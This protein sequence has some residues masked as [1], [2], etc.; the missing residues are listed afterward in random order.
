ACRPD[1]EEDRAGAAERRDVQPPAPELAYMPGHR[2]GLYSRRAG[3]A[4]V[5]YRVPDGPPSGRE[6][7]L[8]RAVCARPAD[9]EAPRSGRR[10][11]GR[12]R[13]PRAAREGSELDRAAL[14]RASPAHR[15]A[16]PPR[17]PG[18]GGGW[19]EPGN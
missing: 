4:P 5:E 19:G 13:G 12:S 8:P 14:G 18:R 3:S 15:Q 10:E 6:P 9:G 17:W 7:R 11:T 2:A 1:A 16:R